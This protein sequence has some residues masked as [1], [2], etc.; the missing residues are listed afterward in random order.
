MKA[1]LFYAVILLLGF[2]Y[3]CN[4]L[5]NNDDS[6]KKGTGVVTISLTDAPFPHDLVEEVNVTID[7]IKF[8]IKED[9]GT[10]EG[11]EGT[12]KASDFIVLEV[13]ETFNLLELANGESEILGDLEIPVGEYSEIRMHV[14]ESKIKLKDVERLMD[15]KIPSGNSRGLKIKINPSLVVTE[16]EDYQILL[17]FDVSRSFIVQGKNGNNGK[18]KVGEITSFMFKPVIRAVN[19]AT[20]GELSG[21]VEEEDDNED[22]DFIKNA[23]IY[24][25]SAENVEDTIATGKTNKE[26]FYKIIGIPVGAYNVTCEKEGYEGGSEP[27]VEIKAG[28]LIIQDFKLKKSEEIEETEGS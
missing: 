11:S 23:H 6:E 20:S 3:G 19:I 22:F 24:I 12:D 10:S 16:G 2:L 14:T 28:E 26:G 1:K 25:I 15:V 17:D 18:G 21:T 27:L 13:D 8:K 4:G 9:Y 7:L 5:V